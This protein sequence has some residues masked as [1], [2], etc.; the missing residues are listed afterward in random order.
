ML[1]N[2]QVIYNTYLHKLQP[3]DLLLTKSRIKMAMTLIQAPVMETR[4]A[5]L[6]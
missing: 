5:A 6:L 3:A 2:T 4:I 1:T